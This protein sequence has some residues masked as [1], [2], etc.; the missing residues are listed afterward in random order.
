[1]GVL[2]LIFRPVCFYK[3]QSANKKWD[4]IQTQLSLP[5]LVFAVELYRD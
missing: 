3:N 2:N 5:R 1:M 4:F